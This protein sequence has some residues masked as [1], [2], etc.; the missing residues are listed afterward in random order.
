MRTFFKSKF[1]FFIIPLGVFFLSGSAWADVFV[2]ENKEL[3]LAAEDIK[4]VFLGKK[5]TSGTSVLRPVDN[6]SI[7]EEFLRKVLSYSKAKYQLNWVKRSFQD[8]IVTPTAENSDAEVVSFVKSNPGGIG[9]VSSDPGA[10]VKV[11]KK[12]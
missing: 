2:I 1:K 6:R 4:D 10:G 5:L 8:G 11:I 7:E 3:N 9:Y 12:Y